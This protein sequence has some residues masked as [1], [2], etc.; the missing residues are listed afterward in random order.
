MDHDPWYEIAYQRQKAVDDP[1]GS[2]TAFKRGILTDETYFTD[3]FDATNGDGE[4]AIPL[5]Y[6]TKACA[7][8]SDYPFT[9]RRAMVFLNPWHLDT[10]PSLSEYIQHEFGCSRDTFVE[11]VADR[12]LVVLLDRSDRYD[13]TIQR[14]IKEL[15]NDIQNDDCGETV[16]PR[17]VNLV[18]LALGAK[19][20]E[21]G[22]ENSGAFGPF[23]RNE[24]PPYRNEYVDI[25]AT[26][27][28]WMRARDQPWQDLDTKEIQNVYGVKHDNL[29]RY[30]TE[31]AAK[32]QL[33]ADA[34]G[35]DLSE[36]G[37]PDPGT[38]VESMAGR[39][40]E[41]DRYEL[42]K[43]VYSDWNHVGTP[44][45]YCDFSGAADV[46]PAPYASYL[47]H[48]FKRTS[49]EYNKLRSK[50][51][52]VRV[53]IGQKDGMSNNIRIPDFDDV[54]T[55]T[56]FGV[57][58][59]ESPDL[60]SLSD[61]IDQHSKYYSRFDGEIRDG[62]VDLDAESRDDIRYDANRSLDNTFRTGNEGASKMTRLFKYA[63]AGTGASSIS[64]AAGYLL[65]GV[66][67][68]LAATSVSLGLVGTVLSYRSQSAVDD[69][70]HVTIPRP[71]PT[72]LDLGRLNRWEV[73]YGSQAEKTDGGS[74]DS[75]TYI[76]EVEPQ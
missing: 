25:E 29:R 14:E 32:L 27:E 4:Q 23:V 15:F 10:E 63:A 58:P 49:K 9:Y 75:L 60:D 48:V 43:R 73:P 22:R 64:L 30:V 1:P 61:R 17:Y 37:D 20:V 65:P 72:T 35:D 8:A 47:N 16:R 38:L 53:K 7:W 19:F 44:M 12:W 39:I 26:I 67:N 18:D 54:K 45:Y 6:Y 24:K 76:E 40:G 62:G 68:L 74:D 42:S 71:E 21:E 70:T 13:R 56:V 31:R 5:S 2:L 33:A 50:V 59:S 28:A 51:D 11:L 41:V 57:P 46:G 52:M 34:L 69:G 3:L 55:S 66:S 36:Q